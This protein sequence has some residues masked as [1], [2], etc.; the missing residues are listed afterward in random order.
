[1]QLLSRAKRSSP[2]VSGSC[3]KSKR[4]MRH[5]LTMKTSLKAWVMVYAAALPGLFAQTR[6]DLQTQA[7]SADLSSMGPTKPAQTGAMLPSRAASESLLSDRG[8]SRTNLMVCATANQWSVSG[9][10]TLGA[11]SDGTARG[12]PLY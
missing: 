10:A 3:M 11:Q 7:K 1:V 4:E 8:A 6:I 5:Y 2:A 12:R 9:G